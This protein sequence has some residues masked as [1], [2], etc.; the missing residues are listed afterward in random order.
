[1][2]WKL[3]VVVCVLLLVG[4]TAAGDEPTTTADK[5]LEAFALGQTDVPGEPW[6]FYRANQTDQPTTSSRLIKQ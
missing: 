5:V 4:P 2:R 3:G 1:M 6:Y